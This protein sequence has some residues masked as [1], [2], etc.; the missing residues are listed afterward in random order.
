MLTRR[1]ASSLHG[2]LA[3]NG[4]GICA[5]RSD[6]LDRV[7]GIPEQTVR[8]GD[9]AFFMSRAVRGRHREPARARDLVDIDPCFDKRHGRIG[10]IECGHCSLKLSIVLAFIVLGWQFI[11]GAN[12]APYFIPENTPPVIDPKTGKT[13]I[14]YAPFFKHG[15]GGVIGGAAIV[16]FAFIGFD[17]VSTA[18]P[19]GQE[20]R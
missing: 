13:I 15:Y 5:R 9:P 18:A 8:R 19:G 7:V 10:Q 4:H 20:P 14:D 2:S 1:W 16:F 11:D 6:G 3:E 17:A 12:H